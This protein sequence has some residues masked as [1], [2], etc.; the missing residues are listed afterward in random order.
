MLARPNAKNTKNFHA[1]D[2][3][4][5]GI[6]I[7]IAFEHR[8]NNRLKRQGINELKAVRI[9][10]GPPITLKKFKIPDRH[11]WYQ[12]I[13]LLWG[14]SGPFVRRRSTFHRSKKQLKPTGFVVKAITGGGGQG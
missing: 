4:L 1:S 13:S 12:K 11:T 8:L 14:Q 2:N 7:R 6:K 9:V 5:I 3:N 10:A